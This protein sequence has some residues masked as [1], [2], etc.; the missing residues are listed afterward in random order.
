MSPA[1]KYGFTGPA[2]VGPTAIPLV[3]T[4]TS[5][6]GSIGI[7]SDSMP[8]TVAGPDPGYHTVTS[9][10]VPHYYDLAIPVVHAPPLP[11]EVTVTVLAAGLAAVEPVR[12]R[13]IRSYE[14]LETR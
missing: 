6:S 12:R 13:R 10:G 8:Q 11:L 7:A 1:G 3:G 9:I 5:M 2:H 14:D 4:A